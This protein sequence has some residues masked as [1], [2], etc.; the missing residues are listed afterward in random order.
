MKFN[1][2]KVILLRFSQLLKSCVIL[3]AICTGLNLSGVLHIHYLLSFGLLFG[4]GMFIFFNVLMMRECFIEVRHK[5]RYFRINITAY[6][7]F[8]VLSLTVIAVCPTEWSV[9]F[10]SIT[11]FMRY[12]TDYELSYFSAAMIFHGIG[13]LSVILAPL[14]MYENTHSSRFW[15]KK[16]CTSCKTGKELL[17]LDNRSFACPYIRCLKNNK[18]SF[19]EQL[20]SS[21]GIK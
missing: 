10:F 5:R 6:L 16:I 21:R 20:E 7:L 12:F 14:G 11:N 17:E 18:C 1:T 4:T 9:W 2:R 19:Y 8:A 13:L 15:K 3:S